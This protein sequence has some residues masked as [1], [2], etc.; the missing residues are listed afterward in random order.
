MVAPDHFWAYSVYFDMAKTL[1]AGDGY[2]LSPG[3]SCAYFPPVYP[4]V[5]AAGILTGHPFGTIATLGALAGSGTVWFVWLTSKRLFGPNAG[6][7]AAAYA[8]LYPYFVWHDAVLQETAVLTLIVTAAIWLLLRGDFWFLSGILLALA[9]LTKANL[10]LFA[11]AALVWI[12]FSA[13]ALPDVRLRRLASTAA[14]LALLVAPWAVRTWRITG[15]PILYSNGGFAL[16]TAQHPLTFDYFP[17][18]SIDDASNREEND[19]PREAYA[20]CDPTTDPH[21]IRC[22]A[23]FWNQGIGF[24]EAAPATALRHAVYKI[25]IAFSPIFSPQKPGIFQ[26]AY[27]ATYFPLLILTGIGT[28]RSRRHWREL[29]FVGA[30]VLAF[31]AGTAV[32][33]GHTAHRM[34]LEPCLMILASGTW[35]ARS[36]SG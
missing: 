16:W 25:W 23:W 15:S 26:W 19:L 36:H 34:Y 22:S 3:H 10:S 35:P 1:V 31:A 4:T 12:F 13:P 18:Q 27:F 30:L 8:S 20:A 28:W 17:Q 29:G 7:A 33:W 9:V 5:L 14:G 32:F 11:A 21:G 2:C 24:I 6:L